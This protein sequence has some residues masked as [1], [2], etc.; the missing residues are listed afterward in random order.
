MVKKNDCS[1]FFKRQWKWIAQIF[2]CDQGS[3]LAC[4]VKECSDLSANDTIVHH[5]RY[6][7]VLVL[8]LHLYCYSVD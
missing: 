6:M 7:V 5:F 4:R 3:I 8:Q 1:F 2:V